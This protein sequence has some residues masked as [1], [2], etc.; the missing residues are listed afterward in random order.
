MIKKI[1]TLLILTLSVACSQPIA[2]KPISVS[3]GSNIQ[4][5]LSLNN[6]IK[7]RDE[8]LI[9]NIIKKDTLHNYLNSGNGFWYYFTK[10][11]SISSYKPSFGDIVNFDYTVKN[12]NKINIYENN[13]FKNQ[14]YRIDKQEL[15]FGLREGLKLLQEGESATFL[16]PSHVAYGFY[17]DL[18]KIGHNIPIISEVTVNSISKSKNQN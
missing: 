10:K 6:K 2:R 4:K 14:E 11:D 1:L 18:E 3:S 15:F 5:S 16:F 8:K 17:G 13:K 7:D 9:K 12:L